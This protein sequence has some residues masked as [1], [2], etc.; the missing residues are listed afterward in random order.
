MSTT[1]KTVRIAT[2]RLRC[3]IALDS[4]SG[5]LSMMGSAIVDPIICSVKSSYSISLDMIS[6]TCS[7]C[8]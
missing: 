3:A 6:E 2:V 8:S 5:S 1:C 7:V 4:N